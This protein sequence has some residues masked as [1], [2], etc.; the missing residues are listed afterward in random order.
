MNQAGYIFSDLDYYVSHGA[1]PYKGDGNVN[2][3]GEL[4]EG[5]CVW[6][7]YEDSTCYHFAWW[8]KLTHWWAF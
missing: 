8:F 1:N 7:K 2:K 3:G 6:Q 4:K 5:V